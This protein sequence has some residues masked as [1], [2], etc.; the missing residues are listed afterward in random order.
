MSAVGYATSEPPPC[1]I[2]D[3]PEPKRSFI[4]PDIIGKQNDAVF[5]L[6]AGLNRR[7]IVPM[8]RIVVVVEVPRRLLLFGSREMTWRTIT[9]TASATWSVSGAIER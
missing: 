3:N 7:A 9:V 6:N 1:G 5:W 8:R 4:I 2:A